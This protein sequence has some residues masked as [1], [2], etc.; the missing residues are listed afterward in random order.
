MEDEHQK[1]LISGLVQVTPIL[2]IGLMEGFRVVV[3][4]LPA[5]GRSGGQYISSTI[6]STYAIVTH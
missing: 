3:I 2:G 6:P 4:D 1:R 5:H